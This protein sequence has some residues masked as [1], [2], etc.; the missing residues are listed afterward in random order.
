MSSSRESST[1]FF[2]AGTRFPTLDVAETIISVTNLSQ[3][4]DLHSLQDLRLLKRIH[5]S[6]SEQMLPS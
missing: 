5:L 6:S 3:K 4:D 1:K 2:I